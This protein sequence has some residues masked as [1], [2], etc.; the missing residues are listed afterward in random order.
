MRFRNF[1]G[2]PVPCTT[3]RFSYLILGHSFGQGIA[4]KGGLL[5]P[6]SGRQLKPHVSLD[7]ILKDSWCRM[8]GH[9]KVVLGINIALLRGLS[10]PLHRF[11]H[12]LGDPKPS[13]LHD[14]EIVLRPVKVLFRRFGIPVNGLGIILVNTFPSLVQ[15][16]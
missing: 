13:P 16:T 3:L 9:P 1:L 4:L 11:R 8:T 14:S 2:L 5:L 7:I 6:L 15:D 10:K 12:I